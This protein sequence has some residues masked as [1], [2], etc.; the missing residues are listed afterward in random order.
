MIDNDKGRLRAMVATETHLEVENKILAEK[1]AR[2]RQETLQRMA[3]GVGISHQREALAAKAILD[4]EEQMNRAM[5]IKQL[6]MER[7]ERLATTMSIFGMTMSLWQ[8]TNGLNAVTKGNEEANEAVMQYQAV[9][10]GTTGPIIGAY[11][12]SYCARIHGSTI[13]SSKNRSKK[14]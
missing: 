10:M 4:R 7:R 1:S 12:C 9:I 6:H 3:N 2:L 5:T 11:D 13:Y 14:K 8:I